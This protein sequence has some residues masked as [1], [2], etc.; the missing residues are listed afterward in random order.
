MARII[1]Q[2][3][4][5]EIMAGTNVQY[6]GTGNAARA[7]LDATDYLVGANIKNAAIKLRSVDAPTIDGTY[8]LGAMHP[9]VAGDLQGE[10]NGAWIEFSKYT[11]PDKLFKGEIGALYGVR[12]SQ[13]SNVQTFTSST[14]VYPTLVMGKGAYGVANFSSLEAIYQPLGSGNDPLKQRATVGS[15]IDFAAKRLQ[16]DSMVRLE[17]A[18]TAL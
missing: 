14:T 11:T 3:I 2:V 12:F 13:S 16:E 9:F 18:A 17:S 8:Y 6:A 7:D 5:T 1:D 10:T 15:K 4:Q